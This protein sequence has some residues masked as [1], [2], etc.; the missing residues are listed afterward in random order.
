MAAPL[1][2]K[3]ASRGRPI[4]DAFDRALQMHKPADQ[5]E[6]LDGIVKSLIAKAMD[7]DIQAAK[8]IFDR[9]EGK[10][11]QQ[12]ELSG[13]DGGEIVARIERVIIDRANDKP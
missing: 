3:N 6:A 13:L 11:I 12:T 8:E 4:R 5:R 1:G 9:L 7:G 2:N 10:P